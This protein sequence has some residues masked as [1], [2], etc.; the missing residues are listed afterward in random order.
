MSEIKIEPDI[1]IFVIGGRHIIGN[2]GDIIIHNTM[3]VDNP[4]QIF[5]LEDGKITLL[6]AAIGSKFIALNYNS[7]EF[8]YN[9]NEELIKFYDETVKNYAELE[10][11][12]KA[13]KAGIILSN[14][15]VVNMDFKKG[16]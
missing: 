7:V 14:N 8:S 9:P 3:Y 12:E 4:F 6:P 16:A 2:K 5:P 13:K 15:K 10:A 1:K 11:K